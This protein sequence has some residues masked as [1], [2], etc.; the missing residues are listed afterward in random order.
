MTDEKVR[1]IWGEAV[2]IYREGKEQLLLSGQ[3]EKMAQA[4]QARYEE[5]NPK[6]G[7]IE[8]YLERLLPEDW[9][10]MD[11][12]AR[13]EWLDDGKEGTVRR[14]RVC[15]I[16]I[17]AE[18]FGGNPDKIDRYI[19]KEINDILSSTPG[20]FRPDGSKISTPYGRQRFFRRRD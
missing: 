10:G 12:Y 14:E 13:R 4:M 19:S 1:Q 7:I 8:E 5:E 9:D 15:S 3:V 17:W 2:S 16:E 6:K 18:A 20:W 11:L